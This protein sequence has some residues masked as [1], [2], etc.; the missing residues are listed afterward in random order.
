MN[1]RTTPVLAL[2]VVALCAPNAAADEAAE[3]VVEWTDSESNAD[4]QPKSDIEG[5]TWKFDPTKL[6]LNQGAS[7]SGT[8]FKGARI[9]GGDGDVDILGT[10]GP[11]MYG[12]EDHE[13]YWFWEGKTL[14]LG[15]S[16][17]GSKNSVDAIVEFYWFESSI[18]R[19]SDFYVMLL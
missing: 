14:Y 19:G 2:L 8:N 10:V 3:E 18:P 15:V 5:S 7:S 6:S 9:L 16:D 11:G 1:I 13:R 4:Y 17:P 12:D